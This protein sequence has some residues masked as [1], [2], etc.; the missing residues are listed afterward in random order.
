MANLTHVL[1]TDKNRKVRVFLLHLNEQKNKIYQIDIVRNLTI[2]LH[3]DSL[4]QNV[5][6]CCFKHFDIVLVISSLQI[7]H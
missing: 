4:G 2:Q 1:Q 6:Q 7:I 3:F 5:I